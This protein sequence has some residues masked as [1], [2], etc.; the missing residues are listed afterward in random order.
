MAESSSSKLQ[1]WDGWVPS[2]VKGPGPPPAGERVAPGWQASAAYADNL[3]EWESL[4]TGLRPRVCAEPFSLQWFLEI[5]SARHGRYGAWIPRLLEFTR[6]SGER[7][8]GLGDGLGTDWVQYARHGAMV[9]AASPYAERLALAQRNFELRGLNGVFLHADPAALPLETASID[10]VCLTGLL[11][12]ARAPQAVVEEVYRVLKPGGKVLAVTPARYDLD[13]WRRCFLPW[14]AWL[15]PRP[16]IAP[17]QRFSARGLRTLFGRFAE[18]R[19]S[20]RHLRKG[21]VPHLWRWLP[22]PLLERLL[23][24]VL[25]FKAFKPLTAAM[26]LQAAA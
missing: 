15:R 6:H 7:L 24:R 20:R 21:E 4:R 26:S 5:E 9:T 22:H 12:D 13:F 8:L 2:L 14:S 10:V 23:G 3:Y 1:I 19:V 25:I 17:G 18:P 11:A 16:R